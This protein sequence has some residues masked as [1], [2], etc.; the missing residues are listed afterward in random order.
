MAIKPTTASIS[1]VK[2]RKPKRNLKAEV[3][4]LV[5][6]PGGEVLQKRFAE[7]LDNRVEFMKSRK[8][9]LG[10]LDFLAQK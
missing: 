5:A 3:E 10:G 6:A 9:L 2:T 8:T 7:Y 1:V 4:A